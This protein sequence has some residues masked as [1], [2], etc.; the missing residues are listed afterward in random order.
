M[1]NKILIKRI[2]WFLTICL[3]LNFLL[4][5]FLEPGKE[6]KTKKNPPEGIWQGKKKL[7]LKEILSIGVREGNENL[8][9][10]EPVDVEVDK[11]GNIYVLEKGNFRIQK[12]GKDGSFILT[13]GRKGQ[14]PGEILDS[15]DIELDSKGNIFVFDLGNRRVSKFSPDGSFI[16]SFKP[17]CGV[18]KG[19]ID[20]EDNIYIYKQH[21][22]KLIHK[23]D[24]NGKH[25]LSFIDEIPI[26][27]KRIEPHINGL[28]AIEF[29]K[30][31]IYLSMIYPYTTYIF[32]KNGELIGRIETEAPYSSPP[33]LSPEGMVI[34]NF[35][36]TAISFSKENYLFLK[37]NYFKVP[38]NWKEKLKE[39]IENF[40]RSSFFDIFDSN[41]SYLLHQEIPDFVWG[42]TFDS[43]GYLYMIKQEENFW[44]IIKFSLEFK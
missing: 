7:I 8:I 43:K 12:F 41:G 26:E 42:F 6:L 15:I 38:S 31:K 25:I 9:F 18:Y 24:P 4:F 5:A 22:G 19:A 17:E 37:A 34:T 36:I 23:Y 29:Y 33:F 16:S 40:P 3:L 39:I 13:I 10:N 20:S 32:S 27:P 21:K 1:K 35:L 14:G 44:R 30:E 11:D 2:F 28:G